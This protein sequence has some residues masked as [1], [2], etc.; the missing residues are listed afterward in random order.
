[1][2]ASQSV[3]YDV[4]DLFIIIQSNEVAKCNLANITCE[5]SLTLDR[6]LYWK[7]KWKGKWK[8]LIVITKL[9]DKENIL[10]N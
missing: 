5:Y 10:L 3:L 2:S 9:F 1:M 8:T 6:V 4:F 7:A